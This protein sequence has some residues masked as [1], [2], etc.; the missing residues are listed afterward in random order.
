VDEEVLAYVVWS[1]RMQLV[2]DMSEGTGVRGK[3]G[4]D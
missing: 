3:I 1:F 2:N 4:Y